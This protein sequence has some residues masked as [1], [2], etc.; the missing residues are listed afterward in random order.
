MIYLPAFFFGIC[1]C[2][3]IKKYGWTIQSFGFSLYFITGIASILIDQFHL[4]QYNCLEKPLGILAPLSYCLLLFIFI[5]PLGSIFR[6]DLLKRI[7]V[8]NVKYLDYVVYFFFGLFLY[9]VFVSYQNIGNILV[10]NTFAEIRQ[11][12]YSGD[13]A[14]SFYNHL[15]GIPRY[16]AALST[17]FFASSFFLLCI[18]FYNITYRNV[19]WY[20]HIMTI[21]GSMLQLISSIS[22]ADR[23]QFLYWFI[24]FIFCYTLFRPLIPAKRKIKLLL[25]ILP[26]LGVIVIYFVLVSISRWGESTNG[27]EGGTLIYAG[28]NF[29]N[30]CNFVNELWDT[31]RSL[32]EIF[33]FTYYILGEKSYFD[34]AH[35]VT[36]ASGMYIAV[37]PSFLGLIFSISG[38]LV[39]IIY[40]IVYRIFCFKWLHRSSYNEVNFMGISKC[41]ILS[42]VPVLGVFG[43]FYMSYTAT[44]AIFLWL[45]IGSKA[46]KK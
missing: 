20:F 10:N 3:S 36:K 16:I 26:I 5:K 31:P 42:L 29:I 11:S 39:L 12:A 4:Y 38:P 41:F 44:L 23:S 6:P 30:Y 40:T 14:E 18:F 9:D 43:Y 37:F 46:S 15:S 34:W 7:K 35:I 2:L 25:V 8:L 32:C 13:S 27:T 17:F 1:T 22:Q 45:Y 19:K 24:V 21:C 28:Q 33:P